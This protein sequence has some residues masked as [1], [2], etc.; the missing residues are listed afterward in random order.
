MEPIFVGV[1]NRVLPKLQLCMLPH[2]YVE[3]VFR[4]GFPD[5]VVVMNILWK[6]II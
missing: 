4:I 6:N 1:I 5:S 3:L 2:G